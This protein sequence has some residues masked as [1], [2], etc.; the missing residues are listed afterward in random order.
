MSLPTVTFFISSPNTSFCKHSSLRWYHH[1]PRELIHQGSLQVNSK[2]NDSCH[3]AQVRKRL[4]GCIRITFPIIIMDRRSVSLTLSNAPDFKLQGAWLEFHQLRENVSELSA[5]V[6]SWAIRAN[7]AEV[8][9]AGD[10]KGL[11]RMPQ[12]LV[13]PDQKHD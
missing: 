1:H 9:G 11:R 2:S 7:K 5:E 12:S 4:Q 8:S 6:S 10:R 13:I 3:D